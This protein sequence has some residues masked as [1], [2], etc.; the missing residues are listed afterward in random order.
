MLTLIYSLE[1]VETII[2]IV[3]R[4]HIANQVIESI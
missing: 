1:M 2:I 3:S 4:R